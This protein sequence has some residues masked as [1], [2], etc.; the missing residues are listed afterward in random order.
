VT[1][2][3]RRTS[4]SI[5]ARG[6]AR[7]GPNARRLVV[8]IAVVALAA[9]TGDLQS[10]SPS[11]SATAT[12]SPP[13]QALDMTVVQEGLT[14]PWDIAFAPD[15]RM[16]VSERPG[17]IRVF[18]SAE[19]HAELLQTIE[20]PDVRARGEAGV[21][22]M[23]IDA[24]FDEYPFLYVCA[25]RD[26][27]GE[28]DAAPWRNELLR[29]RVTD[30]DVTF[31]GT[32]FES[33]TLANRQH[34]GCAVEVDATGHIWMTVGDAL[35]AR[36]GWPQLDRLNGKVLRMNRDGSVPED[37]PSLF[38]KVGL[39]YT[40]GHRN[41]QGIAL[42]PAGGPPYTAEHGPTVNDEVNRIIAGGNYGW[43][44]YLAEDTIPEDIG[45]HAK[46]EIEC[47][48]PSEYLPAAW[49]SGDKTIANSGIVF[50]SGEHWGPW[51]GNLIV[52][53]L[54]EQDLRRFVLDEDG[55]AVLRETLLDTAYG[56][57]RAAVLG[58]DGALYVT[59]SNAQN[60]SQEG[61]TP[62][63]ENENDVIIRVAPAA[64]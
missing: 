27:D 16:F 43:P 13:S 36:A 45:G 39:A 55:N 63:P 40:I 21:M 51:D 37:N 15:G 29:F 9:C 61:M 32:V 56:R 25:S 24:D 14:I 57:L 3:S 20:V 19:P 1:N 28:G 42:D 64:P 33:T 11:H 5:K 22:G 49:S 26:A 47:G 4:V 35:H 17:R 38:G 50:L 18:A 8:A 44:C 2:L 59:T 60:L 7:V 53:S 30:D 23:D 48:D 46:L 31:E 52:A 41:P 54:K 58:P 10:Q 34:N 12:P 6:S 62:A